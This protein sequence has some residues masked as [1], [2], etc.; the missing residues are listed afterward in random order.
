MKP[1]SITLRPEPYRVRK[2]RDQ[3]SEEDWAHYL[4]SCDRAPVDVDEIFL[5]DSYL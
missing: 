1:K 3:Q 5:D 4:A 2:H